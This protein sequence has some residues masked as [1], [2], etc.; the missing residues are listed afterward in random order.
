MEQKTKGL[1]ARLV[2]EEILAHKEEQQAKKVEANQIR[3]EKE[4]QKEDALRRKVDTDGTKVASSGTD[5]ENQ[6]GF[7]D[8]FM[9]K[10]VTSMSTS[11]VAETIWK[12]LRVFGLRLQ[13]Y[14]GLATSEG[15]AV[16]S[17]EGQSREAIDATNIL[18]A[19][20]VNDPNTGRSK[21]Y[22]FVKFA[23][24]MERN[25]AMKETTLNLLDLS[26]ATHS[27]KA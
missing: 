2:L 23:D 16:L 4:L 24:E 7:V 5:P 21:G 8:G 12:L 6:S 20:V 11:H 1:D 27:R 19:K 13:I 10:R 3:I 25:H 14:E 22:V 15:G 18:R 17:M 26:E 9:S